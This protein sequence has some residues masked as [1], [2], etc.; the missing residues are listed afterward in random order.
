MHIKF[1]CTVCGRSVAKNH[2][3][4]QCDYCD[5][6]VHIKCNLIDKKTYELLKQ[7]KTPWSCIKCTENIFPYMQ[8]DPS[9]AKK[10][11]HLTTKQQEI[12]NALNQTTDD[13]E[14]LPSSKYYTPNEFNENLTFSTNDLLM[15][16][17]NISSLSFHYE[18]LYNFIVD[19]PTKPSIFGITESRLKKD[20]PSL[21]NISLPGYNIEHTDTESA[22]GGTLLY[23]SKSLNYINRQDLNLYKTKELEHYFC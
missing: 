16:H 8:T 9:S 15:L 12:I 3:A 5:Q 23:I 1:P 22:N 7:D 21:I 4:L 20:K 14:N 6:W 11:D 18:D 10:H 19:M 2:K 13:F 17:L